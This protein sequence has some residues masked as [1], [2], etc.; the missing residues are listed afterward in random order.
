MCSY[1][2]SKY[3]PDFTFVDPYLS[4]LSDQFPSF[5]YFYAEDEPLMTDIANSLAV[6]ECF[7]DTSKE[8]YE[9][10][11]S[12]QED[13][14]LTLTSYV[15]LSNFFYQF[16]FKPDLKKRLIYY[17][18][19]DGICRAEK[20]KE[21]TRYLP[22]ECRNPKTHEDLVVSIIEYSGVPE[23]KQLVDSQN[24]RVVQQAFN[25]RKRVIEAEQ[26]GTNCSILE[27]TDSNMLLAQLG[28]ICEFAGYGNRSKT[29]GSSTT[30]TEKIAWQLGNY[31]YN[32]Y[33]PGFPAKIF[34]KTKI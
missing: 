24:K 19:L 11:I 27:F 18:Y 30:L 33:Q 9:K 1:E 32:R 2:I 10:L 17:I 26:K 21:V 16:R 8:E 7:I 4:K 31:L 5:C 3:T 15:N 14:I 28:S 29:F 6:M 22:P 25:Y 23:I 13:D 20:A 12:G 34:Q